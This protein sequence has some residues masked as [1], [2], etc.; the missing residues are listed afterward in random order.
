MVKEG[1]GKYA[2]AFQLGVDR[3]HSTTNTRRTVAEKLREIRM[4]R[5]LS[6]K[7]IAELANINQTTY[8]GYENKISQP[9][10]AVLIRIADVYEVSLDYLAG[11]TDDI[12]GLYAS[13][14]IIE[15]CS[16]NGEI[17]TRMA[18]IEEEMRRLKENIK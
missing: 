14:G 10:V 9:T 4:Q 2:A 16:S 18:A 8:S 3:G 6:Q 15:T 17:I 12:N 7:D 13:N 11:R 5:G 1:K